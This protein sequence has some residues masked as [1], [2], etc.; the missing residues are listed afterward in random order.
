MF[1]AFQTMKR[2]I[3]LH[4]NTVDR[5]TQLF[6]SACR[7][8]EGARGSEACYEMSDSS[9]S[10]LPNF[11]S[12]SLVV[13][14]PIG[15]VAVLIRVEIFFRMR[16]EKLAR[17]DLSAVTR[18]QRIGFDYLSAEAAEHLLALCIGVLR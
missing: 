3:R 9:F 15:I 2:R 8:D 17:S 5:R 18:Q 6:E 16:L 7:A 12:R 13:S 10:L 1:Q 4:R 14:S 11:R